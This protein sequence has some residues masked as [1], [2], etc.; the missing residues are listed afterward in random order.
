MKPVL[1]ALAWLF[2]TVAGAHALAFGIVKVLPD[3]MVSILGFRSAQ[4]EVREAVERS[5][6]PRSYGR[7]L[8]DLSRGDLGTTLDSVPVGEEMTA[9]MEASLPRLV[10]ATA[11]VL[12]IVGLVALTPAGSLRPIARIGAFLAFFPPFIA[13]F[14]ALWVMVAL[15]RSTPSAAFFLEP[16]LCGLAVALPAAAFAAAQAA[17]ITERNL[18]MPFAVTIRA[19]GATPLRLRM[20]LLHHLILEIAPTLEKLAIGLMTALLFAESAFGLSG[21]GSLTLRAIRRADLD[22]ILAIVGF[23]AIVIGGLRIATAALRARYGIRAR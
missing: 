3:P 20:R 2:L 21:L 14:L 22:L 13:P 18:L 1:T 15:A 6:P 7:V 19:V 17:A 8:S 12:V 5:H 10:G 23:S 4:I 16:W 11:L 9:G